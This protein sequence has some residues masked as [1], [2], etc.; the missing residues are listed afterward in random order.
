MLT[1]VLQLNRTRHEGEKQPSIQKLL[2]KVKDQRSPKIVLGL[3]HTVIDPVY[4]ML[5]DT[6]YPAGKQLGTF[7]GET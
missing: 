5:S 6:F 4:T 7:L 3:T 1:A 2:Q